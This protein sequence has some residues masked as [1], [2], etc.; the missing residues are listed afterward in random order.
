MDEVRFASLSGGDVLDVPRRSEY[1]QTFHL[2]RNATVHWLFRVHRHDVGFSLRRRAMGHGGAVERDIVAPRR[3]G[4]GVAVAGSWCASD[5]PCTVVV[6]FDNTFSVLRAKRIV[7]RLRLERPTARTARDDSHVTVR[8]QLGAQLSE[9]DSLR[10]KLDAARAEGARLASLAAV[11]SQPE[12][13]RAEATFD[14]ADGAPSS[15]L[16]FLDAHQ[17]G[18]PPPTGVEYCTL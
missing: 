4:A 13:P 7:M 14:D 9:M 3:F 2:E 18:D 10:A 6:C 12:A 15:L 16:A 5:A 11:D 17:A 1:T 8:D